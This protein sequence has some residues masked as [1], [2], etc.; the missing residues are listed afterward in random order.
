MV[1]KTL[2]DKLDKN[3]GIGRKQLKLYSNT[4]LLNEKKNFLY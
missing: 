1:V 2:Q 3:N 4:N